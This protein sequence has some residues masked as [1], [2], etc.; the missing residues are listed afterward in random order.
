MAHYIYTVQ[1]KEKPHHKQRH[2]IER[3]HVFYTK[4]SLL[5]NFQDDDLCQDII[6]KS[7]I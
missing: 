1:N 6:L 3:V 4:Y 5:Y 2:A 7:F